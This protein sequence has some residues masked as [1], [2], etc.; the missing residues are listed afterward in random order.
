MAVEYLRYVLDR[1]FIKQPRLRHAVTKA[2]FGE[3]DTAINLAG[4]KLSVNILRENGYYRAWRK[5][6]GS[7]FMERELGIM[8]SLAFVSARC[9]GFVDVGA[10]IGVFSALMARRKKLDPC[11]EVTAFEP[12]PDTYQRLVKNVAL[13]GVSTFNAALSDR[14][15]ELSFV[16]GAVS[17]VFA[18]T[19]HQNSYHIGS[20]RR[21]I[22]CRRLDSFD[23]KGQAMLVKIDVEG[24]ELEVLRGA[25]A[26]LD[27]GRISAIYCDGHDRNAV[28]K[29][30][31]DRGFQLFDAS[32]FQPSR[33][34]IFQLLAI[35]ERDAPKLVSELPLESLFGK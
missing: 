3:H 34:E 9:D 13:K 10:N 17:H 35:R 18:A 5:S 2:V 31:E 26:L 20:L 12:H 25:S 8:L 33:G 24:H 19:A 6:R 4:L 16:D 15:A 30:L 11:F 23:F 29:F 7:E 1:Y 22:P 27:N 21:Q 32:N 28:P 14:D